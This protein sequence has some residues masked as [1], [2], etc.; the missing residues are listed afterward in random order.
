M[1]E[2]TER[3]RTIRGLTS[4][5]AAD[6]RG[7]ALSVDADPDCAAR[8][9]DAPAFQ[10]IRN[11]NTPIKYRADASA[12]ME[13]FESGSCLEAVIGTLELARGDAGMIL[14]CPDPHWPGCWSTTWAATSSASGSTDGWRTDVPGASSR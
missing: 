4:E 10:T 1:I 12:G 11:A 14:A 5:V 7:R 9:F 13:L 8:H 3:L 2:F 6:L